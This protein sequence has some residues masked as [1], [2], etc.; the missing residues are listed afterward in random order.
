MLTPTMAPELVTLQGGVMVSRAA[1][2]LL[3]D[4]EARG[5]DVRVATDGT[6]RILV[7]PNRLLD[8]DDRALIREYKEELIRLVI[9]CEA[10][11]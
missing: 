9:Y 11:Q 3:W 10:I 8:D 7:G 1:L 2:R 4:F 6:G 5:L